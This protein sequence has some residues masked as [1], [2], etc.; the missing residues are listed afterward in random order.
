MNDP[1]RKYIVTCDRGTI[2]IEGHYANIDEGILYIFKGDLIIA[3]FNKWSNFFVD[4][5]QEVFEDLKLAGFF[6]GA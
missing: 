1:I 6:W 3:S 5:P 2:I 4:L